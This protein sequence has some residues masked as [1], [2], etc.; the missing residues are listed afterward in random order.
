MDKGP[1]QKFKLISNVE[2]AFLKE[3]LPDEMTMAL[4]QLMKYLSKPLSNDQQ[5]VVLLELESFLKRTDFYQAKLTEH[6]GR[7]KQFGQY[8]KQLEMAEQYLDRLESPKAEPYTI[9]FPLRKTEET[10]T[11]VQ[12]DVF[13]TVAPSMPSVSEITEDSVSIP[14]SSIQELVEDEP[15]LQQTG[16]LSQ[17]L[18]DILE[19]STQTVEKTQLPDEAMI[20]DGVELEDEPV[21]D[22]PEDTS[23]SSFEAVTAEFEESEASDGVVLEDLV[24][25]VQEEETSDASSVSDRYQ[26]RQD[27]I[28]DYIQKDQQSG[29]TISFT[30]SEDD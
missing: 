27:R 19:P 14:K 11:P 24:P 17:L 5:Q 20:P 25:D 13:E 4:D 1:K 22:L 28:Q 30:E 18:R 9:Y 15:I 12:E 7:L 26:S 10:L 6:M 3:A 29:S 2:M 8:A 21:A 16:Q 23:D